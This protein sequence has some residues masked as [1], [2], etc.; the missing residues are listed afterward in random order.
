MLFVLVI[1]FIMLT[2]KMYDVLMWA[3]HG[4]GHITS[5]PG[6]LKIADSKYGILIFSYLLLNYFAFILAKDVFRWN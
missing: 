1:N 4:N 2:I 5:G 3:E 6:C